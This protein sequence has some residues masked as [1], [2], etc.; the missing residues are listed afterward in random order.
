MSDPIRIQNSYQAILK[1]GTTPGADKTYKW[2]EIDQLRGKKIYA[3]RICPVEFLAVDAQG[4][5]PVARADLDQILL[6]FQYKGSTNTQPISELVALTLDPESN[7]LQAI[8][9]FNDIEINF[10]QSF[11]TLTDA[12]GI[13]VNESIVLEVYYK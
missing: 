12:T 3:M 11:A 5:T 6:T 13:A 4:N 10:P 1:L 8:P 9:R 7:G 2:P